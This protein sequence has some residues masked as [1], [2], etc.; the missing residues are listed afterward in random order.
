MAQDQAI[1]TL[2]HSSLDH[3]LPRPIVNDF[4]VYLEQNMSL[5]G[6]ILCLYPLSINI[7]LSL[8]LFHILFHVLIEF[9][10]ADRENIE[11]ELE[12]KCWLGLK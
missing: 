9:K 5:F 7:S 4:Y 12:K 3:F 6:Q 8:S 1:S 2:S 11:K 10:I